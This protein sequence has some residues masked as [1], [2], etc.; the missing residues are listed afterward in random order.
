MARLLKLFFLLLMVLPPAAVARGMQ[1]TI[2]DDLSSVD[3]RVSAGMGKLEAQ[4]SEV[5]S[6]LT[7]LENGTKRSRFLVPTDPAKELVYRVEL[8]HTGAQ[9]GIS[10]WHHPLRL[11]D[12]T[13]WLLT[14]VNWSMT[15]PFELNLEVPGKGSAI[16]PFQLIRHSPGQFAYKAYP[17]L[18]DH[19]GLSVFGNAQVRQ[20]AF[21][22][23]GITSVVIGDQSDQTRMLFK[24]IERVVQ[25]AVDVHG[26][27]PGEKSLVV[28]VPVPFVSG[29]VPWAHVMRGGGSHIIAYVKQGASMIELLEDW[30]LFHEMAHLYHPYLHGGGRWVSEGFA[31]YYQN[32][33]RAHAGVVE[34]DYAY[35]RLLAGLERG[36]KEN[37]RAGNRPV[38]QGGRMRTYWTGAALALGADVAIRGSRQDGSLALAM[39]QFAARQMPVDRSW[40]PRDYL[41]A[42]DDELATPVLV[43]MY[44]DYVRDRYFPEPELSTKDWHVIFGL[45]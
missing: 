18:P 34:P 35:Q 15:R 43:P 9:W 42:L 33:Y 14:P 16:L 44:D 45:D 25:A 30:T 7:V 21:G 41:A 8:T 20:L 31:S 26:V 24:W 6:S 27:A 11:S 5:W 32:V 28:V 1:V 29:V 22:D 4:S 13:D 10:R 40:H 19:G 23:T 12:W 38:T 2:A 36:R 17:I 37:V 39:G 3:V